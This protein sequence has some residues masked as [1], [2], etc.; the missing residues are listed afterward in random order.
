MI[1]IRILREEF[2]IRRNTLMEYT[3][4]CTFWLFSI[5]LP[6]DPAHLRRVGG[7]FF[8]KFFPVRSAFFHFLLVAILVG[9]LSLPALSLVSFAT[10][11]S[12]ALSFEGPHCPSTSPYSPLRRK[13]QSSVTSLFLGTFVVLDM[14]ALIYDF[15][16]RLPDRLLQVRRRRSRLFNPAIL[17]VHAVASGLLPALPNMD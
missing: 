7:T 15:H 9:A 8:S 2:L 14:R 12:S 6:L 17:A 11:P 13:A 5:E 3:H 1:K 16:R 10:R 4:V